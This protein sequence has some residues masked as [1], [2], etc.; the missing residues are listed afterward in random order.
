M[1]TLL[2]D[3]DGVIHNN[4]NCIWKSEEIIEG[5]PVPGIKE[6]IN[7]LRETYK[8]VIYST[9]CN[10]IEGMKAIKQWLDENYI[11]VDEIV[12]K[13]LSYATC[14]VDDRAVNFNGNTDKL[15]KDIENF[16]VWWKK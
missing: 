7:K 15:M 11:V 16:K 2:F 13:K 14:F 1:K 9:R 10:K 12:N 6:C 3:F 8:I 4:S 5:C